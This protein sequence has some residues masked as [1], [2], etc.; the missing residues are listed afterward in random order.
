MRKPQ[1]ELGKRSYN[2]LTQLRG[3]G[4]ALEAGGRH[5]GHERSQGGD[6]PPRQ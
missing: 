6:C 1:R 5:G 4:T 3:Y 2:D